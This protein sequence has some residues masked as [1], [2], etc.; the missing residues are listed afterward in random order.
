METP[1]SPNTVDDHKTKTDRGNGWVDDLTGPALLELQTNTGVTFTQA[2]SYFTMYNLA[3]IFGS[4]STGFLSGRLSPY[5]S[6][7]FSLGMI[8]VSSVTISLLESYLGMMGAFACLGV[9]TGV[10]ETVI[11]AEVAGLWGSDT[12]V[13][14]HAV[15]FS[16]DFGS[17][18]SPFSIT[19]FLRQINSSDEAMITSTSPLTSGVSNNYNM[20]LANKLHAEF[21]RKSVKALSPS[22]LIFPFGISACIALL[23]LML[24]IVLSLVSHFNK[25]KIIYNHDEDKQRYGLTGRYLYMALFFIGLLSALDTG[26][27]DAFVDFISYYCVIQ[28]DWP[29]RNS[30]YVLSLYNASC[31]LGTFC[32]VMYAKFDL[33]PTKLAITH[34][35]ITIMGFCGL[36]LSGIYILNVGIWISS[37]LAGFGHSVI[38]TLVCVIAEERFFLITGKIASFIVILSCLGSAV[39]APFISYFMEHVSNMYF[40]YIL[41]TERSLCLVLIIWSIDLVW[42]TG[43]SND[44]FVGDKLGK[45]NYSSTSSTHEIQTMIQRQ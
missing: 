15:W 43:K 30:A 18:L 28:M 4:L 45:N 33:S 11:F 25:F 16:K 40:G 34:T 31:A 1:A 42:L 37:F 2:S 23:A 20:S 35:M 32:G 12:G 26:I 24:F 27:D 19:P 22:K 21:S 6:L 36:I 44:S 38:W 3:H 7:T 5:I 8:A 17:M 29:S 10:M 39:N 14:M 13:P 9:S 41:L